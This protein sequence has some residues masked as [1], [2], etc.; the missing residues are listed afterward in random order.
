MPWAGKDLK[1]NLRSGNFFSRF[2]VVS[3]YVDPPLGG[4]GRAWVVFELKKKMG[5]RVWA[6]KVPLGFAR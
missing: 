3:G 5:E 4:G 2:W 6:G 1:G